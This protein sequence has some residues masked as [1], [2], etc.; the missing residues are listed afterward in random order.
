MSEN[1]CEHL[2]S[3]TVTIVVSRRKPAAKGHDVRLDTLRAFGSIPLHRMLAMA[4]TW[5]DEYLNVPVP[6][7]RARVREWV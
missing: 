7:E 3:R 5:S 2:A 4:E 1:L 6:T